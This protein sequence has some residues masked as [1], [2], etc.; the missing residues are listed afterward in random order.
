MDLGLEGDDQWWFNLRTQTVEQG[1]GDA[2]AER[3]GPYSSKVDAE[4]A[5][6]RAQTRG[7]QWDA[8]DDR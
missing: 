3:M 6:A 2:N 8:D 5:L 7:E 4:T 1:S